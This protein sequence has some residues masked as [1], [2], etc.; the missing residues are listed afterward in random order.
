MNWPNKPT[1]LNKY[2]EAV[3]LWL[4]LISLIE[5]NPQ[6]PEYKEIARDLIR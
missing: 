4:K 2:E 6:S 5:A 3:T 1:C